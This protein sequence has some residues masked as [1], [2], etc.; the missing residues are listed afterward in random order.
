MKPAR[1]F[2]AA[3][4]V[5]NDDE[6]VLLVHHNKIGMWIYPGGHL[7]EQ[8]DP[9]QAALR[10]LREE[11][12]VE[13]HI[14]QDSTFRHPAARVLPSPFAILD[15]D[16]KDA[17]IEFHHHIEMIYVCRPVGGVPRPKLSEISA[18]Q[19]F[20]VS[21]LDGLDVP[22]ELPALVAASI[23]WLRATKVGPAEASNGRV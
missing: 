2:T 23:E 4:L 9:A 17:A 3:A 18:C 12:G 1:H 15:V 5:V 6:R 16:M 20:A 14:V 22:P 13:A 19:W 21:E 8:E 10:E 11:T 7:N